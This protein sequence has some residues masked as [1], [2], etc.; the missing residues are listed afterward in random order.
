M[1]PSSRKQ[2]S[3]AADKLELIENDEETILIKI[4]PVFS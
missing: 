1:I 2:V 3:I 4:F